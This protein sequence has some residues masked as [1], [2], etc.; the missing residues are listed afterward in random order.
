MVW[1]KSDKIAFGALTISLF[2]LAFSIFSYW[3]QSAER[4][5][6]SIY[7]S[8]YEY[9]H[10]YAIRKDKQFDAYVSYVARWYKI[11]LANNSKKRI[12]IANLSFGANQQ[13]MKVMERPIFEKL[14]V[15]NESV[16]ISY[17]IEF[18]IKLEAGDL[19]SGYIL[20]PIGVYPQYGSILLEEYRKPNNPIDTSIERIIYN[21]GFIEM[22][23]KEVNRKL[24]SGQLGKMGISSE[25]E[26]PGIDLSRPLFKELAK[27]VY[28]FSD[29]TPEKDFGFIH[30]YDSEVMTKATGKIIESSNLK[31]N[32]AS[33]LKTEYQLEI[34]TGSGI[35]H[36]VILKSG[37]NALDPLTQ[38]D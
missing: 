12:S 32:I 38:V 29:S 1:Q 25:L 33:P 30:K 3:D 37:A 36:L 24:N 7:N 13:T 11:E 10:A 21:P 15:E 9:T 31:M 19:I 2:S 34:R 17:P 16:E 28:Q 27:G 14:K 5:N 20:L 8:G 6:I 4:V 23:E 18:P 22:Y 26:I 35:K